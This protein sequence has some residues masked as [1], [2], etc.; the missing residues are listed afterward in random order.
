MRARID[1][2]VLIGALIAAAAA[3]RPL[4]PVVLG[5]YLLGAAG[6]LAMH[7]GLRAEFGR[8]VAL[9]TTLLVFGATSLFWSMT[10]AG[11]FI[12]AAFFGVV[13]LLNLESGSRG[14]IAW[15]V[16]IM[17]LGIMPV[18]PV[19]ARSEA[20]P[21]VPIPLAWLGML[22]S[23]SHGLLSLTPVVYIAVIGLA[24]TVRRHPRRTAI[25]LGVSAWWLLVGSLAHP[26]GL[27]SPFG[28]GMTGVLPLLAL[29]LASVIEWARRHPTWALVP[30][31][32]VAL[33]WNYWLMVQFTTGTLPK[34]A[35]VRFAS[36]V[37]QQAD[38]LTR[39]AWLYPFSL[40]ASWWFAWR[41]G[42][43]ADRY[44]LLA[45]Q[46]RQAS[47][48]LILDR[49]ADRYLLEG[50]VAPGPDDRAAL[51]WI[52]QRRASL[53]VPM[54]VPTNQDMHIEV[55]LRARLEDPPVLVTLGLELN[56]HEM[57]RL[58]VQ[59]HVTTERRVRVPGVG[60]PWRT[61]YNRI[62]FVSY[63]VA[64]VD[65]NDQRPPGPLGRRSADQAWPV[66]LYRL[67]ITPN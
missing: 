13:A 29:G 56:G 15:R 52:D 40:P 11:Q 65:P 17:I 57:G 18:I 59:G 43:P 16:R 35:P 4:E 36:L 7:V 54:A 30:L 14:R 12:D 44:E 8:G 27:G 20:S 45:H 64:R 38:V 41:E 23:S 24:L 19:M 33:A 37:R 58:T 61:G 28:H 42:M 67:R 53:A 46:P 3:V 39:S 25:A 48:D 21:S 51:R 66:A 60:R 31:L 34:D 9:L 47:V 2:V 63:G 5:A 26:G 6:L 32:A 62:T 1:L 22:F 55:T 50:W 10:R 49:G